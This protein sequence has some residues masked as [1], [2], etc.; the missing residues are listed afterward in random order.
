MKI[1]LA[2]CASAGA[3]PASQTLLLNSPRPRRI[4]RPVPIWPPLLLLAISAGCGQN[5]IRVYRVAKEAPQAEQTAQADPVK[6][7]LPAGW[8]EVPPGEMRVASFRVE[9]ENGK[10]AD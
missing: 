8:E 6:W 4:T 1:V 9:G 7:K 3:R 10:Q 2:S 5:D